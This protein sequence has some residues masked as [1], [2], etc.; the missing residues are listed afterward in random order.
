MLYFVKRKNTWTLQPYL[1]YEIQN[2]VP[3]GVCPHDIEQLTIYDDPDMHICEC[4]EV[5]LPKIIY[6]DEE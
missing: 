6:E 2:I 5:W 1:E 3:K 4:G